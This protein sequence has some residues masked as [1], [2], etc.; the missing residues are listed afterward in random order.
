MKS[1]ASVFI[2]IVMSVSFVFAEQGQKGFCQNAETT[3]DLVMCI[4]DHHTAEAQALSA[5]YQSIETYYVDNGEFLT[6]LNEEQT[7]WLALKDE[8]C[9]TEGEIYKGGSLQ[10]VQ[11]LSCHA[12]L[13]SQRAEH[14]KVILQSGE[15][16]IVPE[17]S[18]P[19]RWV[20][21]L[22][23]DHGDIFWQLGSQK[24][25]DTECDGQDEHLIAGLTHNNG[26]YESVL[27]ISDSDL[28]GRPTTALLAL[29]EVKNCDIQNNYTLVNLPE[30]KPV[31]N[32][33]LQCVQN[34][35]VETAQCGHYILIKNDDIYELNKKDKND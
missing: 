33:K 26:T 5:L 7:K 20:N 10:R 4:G 25:I 9:T 34:V 14:F 22:K 29:D 28:T 15:D 24:M 16:N 27:A 19:P 13:T 12:R 3:A 21:V 35:I 1:I 11:E 32:A 8:I 2:L 17:F 31:D 23:S 30:P 6:S 18:F